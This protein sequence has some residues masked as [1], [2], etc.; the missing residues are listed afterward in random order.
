MLPRLCPKHVSL[1]CEASV[2]AIWSGE[3]QAGVIAL[4]EKRAGVK[5]RGKAAAEPKA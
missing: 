3:T 1:I 5:V 2:T 4:Y